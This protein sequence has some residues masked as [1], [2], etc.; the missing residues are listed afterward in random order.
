[1]HNYFDGD[2]SLIIVPQSKCILR[3]GFKEGNEVEVSME[4]QEKHETNWS[5]VVVKIASKGKCE[6]L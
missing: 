5:G 4:E 1:M 2:K 3:Q 6:I